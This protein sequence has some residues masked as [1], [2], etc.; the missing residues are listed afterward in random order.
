MYKTSEQTTRHIA[1]AVVSVLMVLALMAVVLPQQHAGAVVLAATCSTYHTVASG[2]TLSS[3][4]LKYNVT[5]Q[6]LAAANEL[7]EPY[8][9]FVGQRL[10]IPGNP[11]TPVATD[12]SSTSGPTFTAKAGTEPFT[13]LITTIGYPVKSPYFVRASRADQTASSVKLGTMKTN[14]KGVATRQFRLPREF[15]NVSSMNICLKNAYTDA[16]ECKIYKP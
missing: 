3:I 15:R 1:L 7:K 14:K 10:C 8:T 16:V 13:V 12:T 11:A 6:E 5:T 4:A 2:E 9:I